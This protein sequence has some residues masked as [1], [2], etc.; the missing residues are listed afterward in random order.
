MENKNQN[1]SFTIEWHSIVK[2]II[3]NIFIIIEAVLIGLMG[4]YIVE[5][6][7]YQP[8]YT[9]SATFV[10]NVKLGNTSTNSSLGVTSEIANILAEVFKQ[11]S[12]RSRAAQYL[13]KG[14]FN[15]TISASPVNSTNL[16]QISVTSD[17][18][19]DAYDLV[20]AVIAVYPEISDNVFSNAVL[21]IIRTPSIPSAPSNNFSKTN[22][23]MIVA[24][25][26]FFAFAVIIL[27][28][29]FRDTIKDR[30]AF[31]EK[32]DSKLF[33]VIVHEKKKRT[34]KDIKKK[35]ALL[36]SESAFT[37]LKF[38]EGF[39]KISAKLEYLNHRHGDR[40]FA[41][42]SVAE[43]EGKSTVASN[44]AISLADMGKKV[45]LID[46]DEKKPALYKIFGLDY[47]ENSEL[48]KLLSGELTTGNYV[49]RRYKKSK[50]FL[51]VNTKVY[52]DYRK[53][54]G[55]DK[56]AKMLNA[57]KNVDY[58]ILDTAPLSVDSAVTDIVEMA[59][60][61]LLVVR[62]DVVHT[63]A[64]NDAILTIKEVGGELAGCVLNDVYPEFSLLG[65][66]GFD[67][68]GYYSHGYGRYS[69]YGRYGKYGKYGRYERYSRYGRY[70]RSPQID[71]DEHINDDT[72]LFGD[73]TGGAL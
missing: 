45:L 72:L 17:D 1:R 48:N 35:K 26:A 38:S 51:A 42:T 25:C 63:S 23:T 57:I 54:Y 60:K 7:M 21:S 32:V 30:A 13:G 73:G 6:K 55:K 43:N 58:I 46:L 18:P 16:L 29:I 71:S 19:Q 20:C 33:G 22:K 40:I 47:S 36:I 41:I 66:S 68:T 70:A 4:A 49:F 61:T 14:G 53:S 39:R 10:V 5:H 69:H 3:R 12:M 34:L 50:L 37:S 44:I 59:D 64:V 15:G 28:S 11:P 67:E 27:F 65:Q 56:I 9:S 2:D 24:G 31:E 52:K 62:T 8:E